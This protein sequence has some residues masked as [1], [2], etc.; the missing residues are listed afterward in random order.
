MLD[1]KPLAVNIPEPSSLLIWRNRNMCLTSFQEIKAFFLM[2]KHTLTPACT[3]TCKRTHTHT[4]PHTFVPG[5]SSSDTRSNSI[6]H[7]ELPQIFWGREISALA[8]ESVSPPPQKES[9]KKTPR[10]NK[11]GRL[12]PLLIKSSATFGFSHG[13]H[14]L[15]WVC[16]SIYLSL[17][18]SVCFSIS[19]PVSLLGIKGGR[20]MGGG[21]DV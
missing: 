11:A 6:V 13:S 17:C 4:H 18:V 8:V 21:A 16:L 12:V 3:H 2:C 19:L 5:R 9:H 15:L 7:S 14:S 20:W 1:F 10:A